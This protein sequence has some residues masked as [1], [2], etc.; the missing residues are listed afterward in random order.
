M[1]RMYP[2]SAATDVG[3]AG[4]DSICS[5]ATS[6]RGGHV[7]IWTRGLAHMGGGARSPVSGL[8]WLGPGGGGPLSVAGVGVGPGRPGPGLCASVSLYIH[9]AETSAA[10]LTGVAVG[11]GA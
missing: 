10:A 7:S 8:C 3:P 11:R 5:G 4:R 2:L 6:S 1:A 9:I